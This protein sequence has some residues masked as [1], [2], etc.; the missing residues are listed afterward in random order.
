MIFLLTVIYYFILLYAKLY[1]KSHRNSLY[2]EV[3]F[4]L[5][6]L[7]MVIFIAS[8]NFITTF[9]A[10][11]FLRI[12]SFLLIS[13]YT[14]RVEASKSAVKAIL[15][16]KV[17]NIALIFAILYTTNLY[18]TGDNLLTNELSYFLINNL[19]LSVIRFLLIICA[20]TKCAQH[21]FSS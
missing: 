20:M 7:S 14:L 4:N 16:N 13:F 10:W 11:E 15:M 18:Q 19:H 3:L 1:L 17:G 21:I 8:S 6:F 2:F 5:F 12:M 9:V